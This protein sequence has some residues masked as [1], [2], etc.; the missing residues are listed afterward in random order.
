MWTVNDCDASKKRKAFKNS[1]NGKLRGGG[2]A[3]EGVGKKRKGVEGPIP[4]RFVG[5]LLGRPRPTGSTALA[6]LS[7]ALGRPGG[8]P[9][10]TGRIGTRPT[11]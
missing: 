4:D 8:R 7:K 3:R 1:D 9:R 6:D 10:L 11:G 2:G 5:R